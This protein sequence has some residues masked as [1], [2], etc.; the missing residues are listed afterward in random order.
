MGSKRVNHTLCILEGMRQ[1]EMRVHPE[2][3]SSEA[4][5]FLH[6]ITPARGICNTSSKAGSQAENHKIRS[7]D[8]SRDTP[9]CSNSLHRSPYDSSQPA[10]RYW[11]RNT[12]HAN[13][14]LKE[15]DTMRPKR[16]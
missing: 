11:C 10:R 6:A 16:K 15:H 13:T 14:S 4:R 2:Y 12:S 5:H 9:A 8:S 3:C 1:R 7:I